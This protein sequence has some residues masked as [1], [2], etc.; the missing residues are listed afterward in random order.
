MNALAALSEGASVLRLLSIGG[1]A[2]VLD[3]LIL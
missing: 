1:S 2:V 3:L